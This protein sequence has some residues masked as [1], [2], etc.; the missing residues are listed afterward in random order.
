MNFQMNNDGG[1]KF[2]ISPRYKYPTVQALLIAYG[3]MPIRSKK[4]GN[5]KIF[6]LYPIPVDPVM[7]ERHKAMLEDKGQPVNKL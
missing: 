6:L 2:F 4:A 5:A 3:S 1:S 7:E